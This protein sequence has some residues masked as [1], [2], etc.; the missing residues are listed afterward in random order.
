MGSCLVQ[1]GYFQAKKLTAF[2]IQL[3][4]FRPKDIFCVV[5]VGHFRLQGGFDIHI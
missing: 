1:Y 5:V 2:S 4:Q 3:V